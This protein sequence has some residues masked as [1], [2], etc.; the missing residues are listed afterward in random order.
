MK[1]GQS[2]RTVLFWD[3]GPSPGP[4][5]RAW[6]RIALPRRETFSNW[7]C[8]TIR[9]ESRPPFSF[10]SREKG[11]LRA[12][13]CEKEKEGGCRLGWTRASIETL[14]REATALPF[15]YKADTAQFSQPLP[16]ALGE[17]ADALLFS[18]APKKRQR[19]E[20]GIASALYQIGNC[21]VRCTVRKRQCG[22]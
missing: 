4:A 10:F 7:F 3:C 17:G 13:A 18:T 14:Q 5:P 12:R 22:Q 6:E 11:K 16:L 15:W 20:R 9:S 1:K 21:S 2:P 19:K 8:F